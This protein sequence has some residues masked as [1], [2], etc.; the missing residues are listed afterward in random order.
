M[1]GHVTD[2][3]EQHVR[4][5]WRID[6]WFSTRQLKPIAMANILGDEW[7]DGDPKW[8][9]ALSLP[10][11]KL[12]LYGKEEAKPGRKMGHLTSIAN[13]P[14]E[15]SRARVGGSKTVAIQSADGGQRP[16]RGA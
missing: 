13:S 3:F 2:Q 4:A 1:E 10:N 15:A 9:L 8:H 6:A 7:S 16:R 5:V 14:E 11:T 12:H